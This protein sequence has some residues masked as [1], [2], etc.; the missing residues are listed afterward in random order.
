MVCITRKSQNS[1]FII[2][3][4]FKS[5]AGYNGA[6]TVFWWTWYWQNATLFNLRPHFNYTMTMVAPPVRML[7][8]VKARQARRNL[9]KMVWTSNFKAIHVKKKVQNHYDAHAHF[10][11]KVGWD[12]SQKS[13]FF[14]ADFL[15]FQCCP[16][17]RYC[18]AL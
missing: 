1:R 9:L 5:R 2:E 6:C 7:A 4:C 10:S 13:L 3:S 14:L 16:S 11:T 17:K 18:N 12:K 8:N 15:T